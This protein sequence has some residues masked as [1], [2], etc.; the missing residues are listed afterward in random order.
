MRLGTFG[1]AVL[2]TSGYG[3]TSWQAKRQTARRIR[4]A[5]GDR[6]LGTQRCGQPPP[7][8]TGS[9]GSRGDQRRRKHVKC[10]RMP[11]PWGSRCG[12]ATSKV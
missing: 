7:V 12:T 2:Q 4:G 1:A 5:L 8:H 11:G 9:P 6:H 10:S 3:G